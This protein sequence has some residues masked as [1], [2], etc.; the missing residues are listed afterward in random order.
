VVEAPSEEQ[1][2]EVSLDIGYSGRKKE[3]R[4]L[5]G[6]VWDQCPSI[7]HQ[8]SW[9]YIVLLVEKGESWSRQEC[10]EVVGESTEDSLMMLTLMTRKWLKVA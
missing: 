5:Y 3:C 8:E 1:Y 9:T 7:D 4:R 10:E 6:G 2:V